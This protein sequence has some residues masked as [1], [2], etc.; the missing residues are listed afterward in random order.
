MSGDE[1]LRLDKWL[2]F[3]RLFK[4][5]G[6]AVERIEAGGIRLNGQPCRKPGRV[7]HVGDELTVS[8]HGRV[9]ALRVLALG[10]RRGPAAEAQG[11]YLEHSDGLIDPGEGT[12]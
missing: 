9:R 8:A 11:L 6:L 12:R 4:S 2:F 7:L 5:R 10:S 3:A 1:G